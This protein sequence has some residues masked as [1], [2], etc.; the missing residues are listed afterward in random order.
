M[1][2]WSLYSDSFLWREGHGR[3][4]RIGLGIT[5]SLGITLAEPLEDPA[6]GHHS[7][8]V[9]AKKKKKRNKEMWESYCLRALLVLTLFPSLGASFSYIE[10]KNKMKCESKIENWWPNFSMGSLRHTTRYSAIYHLPIW[11]V[12]ILILMKKRFFLQVLWSFEI[13]E[14][15]VIFLV[16][17]IQTHHFTTFLHKTLKMPFVFITPKKYFLKR[18]CNPRL[19]KKHRCPQTITFL[20][21]FPLKIRQF[22]RSEL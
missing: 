5:G 6:G 4:G 2:D 3:R 1:V 19:G 11:E 13:S 9:T 18:Y 8:G 20:V 16:Y 14:V 17:N 12:W 21:L 22:F 15:K 10:L 7:S